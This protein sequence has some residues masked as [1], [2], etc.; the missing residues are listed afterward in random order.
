MDNIKSNKLW[1]R[2][3]TYG[4]GWTPC[5]WQGWV[6]LGL[7]ITSCLTI[8]IQI[9]RSG[10]SDNEVLVNFVPPF[11]SIT[12]FLIVVCLFKGEK[13]GWRWGRKEG[14]K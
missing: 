10:I 9:D 4:Y 5:S 3:K 14:D 8:F 13:P 6:V 1:F 11:I 2:S 7:Y 12:F